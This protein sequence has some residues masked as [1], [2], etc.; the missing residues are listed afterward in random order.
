MELK[1]I[2]VMRN[3]LKLP[4]GKI[5]AQAA[6]ASVEAAWRSDKNIFA[7]WRVDGMKKVA[8]KVDSLSE[9]YAIEQQAKQAGLVTAIITDAGRTCV[10]PGTVTCVG[11]GPDEEKKIDAVTGKLQML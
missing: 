7:K 5:A 4:K 3:D 6:H 9:L 11:I 1:Q 2:I 10:E 8:L